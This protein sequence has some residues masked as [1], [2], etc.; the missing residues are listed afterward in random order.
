MF[1]ENSRRLIAAV[2]SSLITSGTADWARLCRVGQPTGSDRRVA[3]GLAHTRRIFRRREY[4]RWACSTELKVTRSPP[5]GPMTSTWLSKA[6]PQ[7]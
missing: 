2:T 5:L 1:A 6:I 3:A 7:A 4:F